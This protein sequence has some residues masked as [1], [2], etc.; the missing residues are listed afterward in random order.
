MVSTVPVREAHAHQGVR[1]HLPKNVIT[2]IKH[3][4]LFPG[5]FPLVEKMVLLKYE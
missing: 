4:L 2:N 5:A 1:Y 3:S